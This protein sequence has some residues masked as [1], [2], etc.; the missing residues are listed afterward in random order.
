MKKRYLLTPGPTPVPENILLEMA[1]PIIHH[2]TPEFREIFKQASE[3]LKYLMQT[4]SNVYTMVSSGSGAME[5]ACVNLVGPG[6]KGLVVR[7]GKFGERFSEILT[8]YGSV[9]ENI[10]V[11][12][13]DA[14]DPEQIRE[15]LKADPQIKA[16][17]TTLCETSTGVVT[18]IKAIARITKEHKAVL[19]VDAISALGAERLEMDNWGVDVVVSGSQKGLM[20]PP[21]LAFIALSSKAH[22]VLE[23]SKR[24]GY[25]FDLLKY[26]KSFEKDDTP[27]TSAVTL[28]IGLREA[29]KMIRDEGLENVLARHE[30]LANAVKAGVKALGLELFAKVPSNVLTAVK[31]PEGIDGL[32]LVK[33]LRTEYGV[34]VAGGQASMKG[35][36]FRIA[37]LG[38][39]Q[40]FDMIIGISALEIVLKKLGYKFELGTGVKAVLAQMSTDE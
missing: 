27:W 13:G 34:S 12:Y 30:R 2:R 5:A 3:G 18:D 31:V 7:G 38:Y 9:P 29:L 40:D 32:A 35:K 39:M 23:N 8:A 28:V 16:V 33:T 21:G 37:H 14:V 24:R 19:V 6:E 22:K 26:H 1:R 4:K 11:E 25:Y 20:L 17:F 15:K 36:I 10:D